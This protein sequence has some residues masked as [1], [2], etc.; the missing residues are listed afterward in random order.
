MK[1]ISVFIFASVLFAGCGSPASKSNSADTN[2][3]V[4]SPTES[5][6]TISYYLKEGADSI[7]N[8][9]VSNAIKNFGEAIKTNPQDS[10]AYA[11]LGQA[12]MRLQ[13]YDQ[14]AEAFSTGLKFNPENGHLNYLAAVTYGLQGD[15]EMATQ[16]AQKSVQIFQDT[17]DEENFKRSLALLHGLLK[18]NNP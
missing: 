4:K 16:H 12:Y 5:A 13:R 8:G 2:Q 17:H 6:E 15:K 9:D 11:L 1:K 7:N 10:R 18:P 14:A 3:Q